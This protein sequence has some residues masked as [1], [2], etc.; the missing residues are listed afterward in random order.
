MKIRMC[1]CIFFS[2]HLMMIHVLYVCIVSQEQIWF[3]LSPFAWLRYLSTF[4]FHL[5]KV[6]TVHNLFPGP[7]HRDMLYVCTYKTCSYLCMYFCMQPRSICPGYELCI[8]YF[9][10]LF[11]ATS[12]PLSSIVYLSIQS[13]SCFNFLSNA[14][15]QSNSHQLFQPLSF[16][17][18][19]Y[20]KLYPPFMYST[21]KF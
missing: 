10:C 5:H 18:S 7:S 17:S 6:G 9:N 1:T 11:H 15:I 20:L 12:Q 8:I 4:T 19:F 13:I 3:I 14:P 2:Q 21:L 16:S